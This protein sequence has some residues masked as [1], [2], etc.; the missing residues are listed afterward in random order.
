[1]NYP[2]GMGSYKWSIFFVSRIYKNSK[3]ALARELFPLKFICHCSRPSYDLQQ[4]EYASAFFS[5]CPLRFVVGTKRIGSREKV[6]Q[7]QYYASKRE[8]SKE[9]RC[10]VEGG[11]SRVEVEILTNCFLKYS[12]TKI[13]VSYEHINGH[14]NTYTHGSFEI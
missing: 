14:L 8:Q 12:S 6:S 2:P 7:R 10:I 11:P 5:Q 3:K 9:I 4:G 1:M 13:K